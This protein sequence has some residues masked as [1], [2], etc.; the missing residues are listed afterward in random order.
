MEVIITH[1]SSDFDSFAGMVAA[2]KLY[3]QAQIILPSSINQN[4]RK[5]ITLY[6]DELP[7]LIDAKKVDFSEVKRVIIIDTKFASR[8]G[9]AKDVLYNKGVEIIVYDHHKKSPEDIRA[10]HD[11]SAEV[12]ASTTILVNEIKNKKINIS[13]LDATL[14]ILGI[15][16]DTGSFTYPGTTSKDLEAASFLME[17]GANLF[18]ALKF[19]NL[20]L[21]R[22]QHDLLEKLIMNCWKIKI[23]ETEVLLSSAEMPK[24]IEGL[25]VLTRKLSQIEDVSVV[26]CWAKMK[27]KIYVVGRSDDRDVDVSEVL[28]TVGGGG[29]P[30]AAS[31]IITDM[32]F[33]EIERKII[34]SL[35]K[36][37]KE[38]V[39]A[40]D[41]MSY[42]VKVVNENVSISEVDELLKKYG[43]SGIPIVDRYNN[44]A[45]IITRKD[46]DRAIGHDLSHAPVKGFRSH[47]IV[48]A[49]PNT[50][51]SEIQ[52][53]MIENGIG[54]VPIVEKKKI[55]GIVTR[56]DILRFLHGRS[57]E[58]LWSFF[59]PEVRNILKVISDVGNTLKYNTY[60]VGGIVRDALL[61]IPNFDI[62]IVVEGDGIEFGRELSKRFKCKFES[63]QKFG[64]SVIIL[65]SGQHIDVATARVEYY[66]SPAALPTVESGNIRQDLARRDFTIN[67]MA[68]SL[69]KKNFGEI[70][71]FFGGREDLKNKKIK[72]LHK[73]SF[74]EDPTRIF[75]AVRFENRLGF[76]MD[77]QTE[78]LA[79]TTINMNIVSELNGVRIRDELISIFSEVNP[80]KAIKRLGELDALKKIGIKRK[81]NDRFLEELK[82]ILNYYDM[83]KDFYSMEGDEIKKWRLIFILLLKGMESN[84]INRW[85]AEMKVRKK[86]MNVI[87]ETYRKWDGVKRAL[88]R[89]IRKNSTLYNLLSKIPAELQVIAC[90]W[91]DAYY[92]NVKKYLTDLRNIHLE[93]S[94]ETL[95]EMGYKP[96]EKFRVVLAKLFEM[97][98][99]GKV[100]DREDEIQ[101]LKELMDSPKV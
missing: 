76:K 60:L 67:T 44:I 26:I 83:L 71:D 5:F 15:Y 45:G 25:S 100:K 24:F 3:P 87:L 61:K 36:N 42:P 68:L 6:E 52:N 27:E 96:S 43:H 64:T 1:L 66:K 63:H 72:V 62:D 78:E 58:D 12:G 49:G 75:R 50:P 37:I 33:E 35:K 89:E 98:L 95:K 23:N 11:F 20:S 40:R 69:N 91:G 73:M 53:L 92:K 59:T 17:K 16:E 55:V 2:K 14:F 38:P 54:R 28:K 39:L 57:Y 32:N 81:I 9:P 30:Q 7:P 82:E 22:D 29:H 13:P 65:E 80:V 48:K 4:V 47:G 46:V 99:D 31:A 51:L 18:V 97:K 90:S 56:K 84:E 93:T 21:T 10:T 41:V 19:L 77:S 85:C 88:R 94:G 74:I 8:L 79:R 34:D 101:M 86:D 70:L